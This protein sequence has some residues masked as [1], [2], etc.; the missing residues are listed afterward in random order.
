[1]SDAGPQHVVETIHFY[2]APT[3]LL[4]GKQEIFVSMLRGISQCDQSQVT[5]YDDR[6]V[7]SQLSCQMRIAGNFR[8]SFLLLDRNCYDR[9]AR[10]NN[11]NSQYGRI[12]GDC[13]SRA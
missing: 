13:A 5:R 1:V 11:D 12:A 2:A 7:F 4:T 3:I 10:R 9:I 8:L 6:M